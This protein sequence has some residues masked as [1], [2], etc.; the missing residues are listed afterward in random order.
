[1]KQLSTA[2]P[3]IA[4]RSSQVRDTVDGLPVRGNETASGWHQALGDGDRSG[5]GDDYF[6]NRIHADHLQLGVTV[7]RPD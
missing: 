5:F 4:T 2:P 6:A 3:A 7:R 1:M